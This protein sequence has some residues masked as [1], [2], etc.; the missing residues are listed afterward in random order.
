MTGFVKDEAPVGRRLERMLQ[1][2]RSVLGVSRDAKRSDIKMAYLC[3]VRDHHPDSMK[4]AVKKG[5][6]D[7]PHTL[8]TMRDAK[9]LLIKQLQD[10]E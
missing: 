8:Q 3:Y 10:G 5:S 9:D 1:R 6:F 2:A 4:D 7:L